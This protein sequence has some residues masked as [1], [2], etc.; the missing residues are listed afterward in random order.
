MNGYLVVRELQV[1]SV[2]L[3]SLLFVI[4]YAVTE[5][6]K[7]DPASWYIMGWGVTCVA[8]FSLS[9]IRLWSDAEWTRTAGVILGFMVIFMV[10]WMLFALLW[11]WRKRFK[12]GDRIDDASND[13][14]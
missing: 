8:A 11:V 10:W 9:A 14:K 12:K 2:L 3:P 6:R 1:W 13:D 5:F 7:K 4:G